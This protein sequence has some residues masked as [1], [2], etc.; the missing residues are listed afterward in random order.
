MS[1]EHLLSWQIFDISWDPYQPNRMVSCGVKHIKVQPLSVCV[2]SF[3]ILHEKK[4]LGVDTGDFYL[5]LLLLFNF[6]CI[7]D[8][9]VCVSVS[10]SL[11][12]ELH[13][14]VSCHV[15]VGN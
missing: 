1:D 2:L 12:L 7:G 13:T 9:L 5:L 15:G 11:E 6:T 10:D 4:K 14:G 8:L 3:R